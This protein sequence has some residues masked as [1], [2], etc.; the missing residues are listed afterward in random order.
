MAFGDQ[1]GAIADHDRI[2]PALRFD[3]L[4][5]ERDLSFG[6]LI[7]VCRMRL[8]FGQRDNLIVGAFDLD[9]HLCV[10]D[11]RPLAYRQAMNQ[12]M[13]VADAGRKGGHARAKKLSRK[14]R[15]EIAKQGYLA[16]PLSDNRAKRSQN[17]KHK[18]KNSSCA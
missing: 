4:G 7:R 1:A 3:D 2:A 13:T 17:G 9:F 15:I 5:E 14:R 12:P 11:A 6:M 8:E 10:D 18:S 16:S